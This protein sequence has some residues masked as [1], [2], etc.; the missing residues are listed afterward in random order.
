MLLASKGVKKREERSII[1][2]N[3]LYHK[4]VLTGKTKDTNVKLILGIG[5]KEFKRPYKKQCIFGGN[6]VEKIIAPFS[7]NR[8]LGRF[9]LV[10][11]MSVSANWLGGW[12]VPFP[13]NFFRGLSLALR[14]HDQF[15]ASHWSTLLPYPT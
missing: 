12:D 6:R 4:F 8:P 3:T 10:V 13:C 15:G 9:G 1:R 14:S 7:P 11:A 2:T 5:S